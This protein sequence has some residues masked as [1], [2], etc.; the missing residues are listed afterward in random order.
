MKILIVDD[1][2]FL[3]SIVKGYLNKGDSPKLKEKGGC[4]I[5]EA[6]NETEALAFFEKEERPDLVLLD[7]VMGEEAREGIRVLKKIKNGNSSIK[8][9]MLTAVGQEKIIQECKSLGADD[10]MTKPFNE[11]ELISLVE[12]HLG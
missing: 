1:S 4:Q 12:K 3:R 5:L 10:Y 8:V 9:I 6:A 7:I 2:P 11:E